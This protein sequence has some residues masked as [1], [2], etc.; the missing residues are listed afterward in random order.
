M[1]KYICKILLFSFLINSCSFPTTQ[2]AGIRYSTQPAFQ[3]P[4]DMKWKEVGIAKEL[5]NINEKMV[6]I[7][8]GSNPLQLNQWEELKVRYPWKKNI[9]RHI[10]IK[11]TALVRSPNA[12]P[13]CN[14]SNC[15]IERDY[16]SYSW[17]ELA[18]H[19]AIYFIPSKT[20]MLK[21][22]KGYLVVKI[23][24]KC[25]ILRFEDEIY[26]LTDNKGN[27]YVMHATRNRRA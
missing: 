2:Q 5:I 15:L 26:Q 7:S 4:N 20:N 21:Q 8:G 18:Q 12:S 3:V 6:I 19:F 27:Y 16:K 10:L 25:Q 11:K 9:D 1:H 22:Q 23:I 14:G 24:K 13:N 17:F